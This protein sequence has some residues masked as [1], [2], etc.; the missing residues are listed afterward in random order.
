MRA[1]SRTPDR[2]GGNGLKSASST[3]VAVAVPLLDR[4]LPRRA[5]WRE[6]LD[7]ARRLGQLRDKYDRPVVG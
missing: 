7:R 3:P 5:A 6:A 4:S 1:N 2:M